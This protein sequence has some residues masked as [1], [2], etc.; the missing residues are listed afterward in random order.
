MTATVKPGYKKT[1]VGVI[2]EEWDDGNLGRF[3]GVTDCKHV[4]A[5]FVPQGFPLASIREV[6]SRF[7][8]LTNAKQTTP[9]R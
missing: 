8:D 6:Q 3:W 1:E 5:Q 9:S 4:T 7:V 2:P